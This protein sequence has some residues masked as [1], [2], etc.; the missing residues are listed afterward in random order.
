VLTDLL[1]FQLPLAPAS[2]FALPLLLAGAAFAAME[3]TRRMTLNPEPPGTGGHPGLAQKSA[4][5]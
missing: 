3:R 2:L 1:I 5:G 4:I